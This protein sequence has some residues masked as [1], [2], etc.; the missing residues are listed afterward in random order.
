MEMNE[1]QEA[2]ISSEGSINEELTQLT[3]MLSRR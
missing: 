2:K 1:D 3:D